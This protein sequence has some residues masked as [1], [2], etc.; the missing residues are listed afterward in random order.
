MCPALFGAAFADEKTIT[1]IMER[2]VTLDLPAERVF[3]GFYYPDYIAVGGVESFDKVVGFSREVWEGWTPAQWDL[4]RAAMPKLEELPDVG[5][6]EAGT[7]SVE[8]LLALNPDVAVLA[9]WQFMALGPDVDR[10]EEAGIKVVVV[11][12]NAETLERHLA[13]TRLFGEITGNTTRAEEIAGTYETAVTEVQR[14]IAEAGREKPRF[15]VEFANKGPAEYSFTYGKNM[16]GA[17]SDTAG[18]E[19]IAK[20]FVE[21]WGPMNPEQVLTSKPEVVLL[22]GRETE[23]KKNEEA[24]VMGVN[25]DK[26][27]AARRLEGYTKRPGWAELPAVQN[28][29]VYGVYQGA[30]RTI[31]DYAMVQFIAKAL[32]PDLFADLNPEAEYLAF[33]QKYLPITPKGTFTLKLGE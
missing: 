31:A 25:I 30:S 26:A 15:Y 33:H 3:L 21:W 8:K 27:E 18:A 20:P 13:S 29:Q 17:L 12:Y 7:F 24:L 14:R 9:E 22:A 4:Y 16:W 23:L 11:D 10:I 2:E 1:D 28:G 32:Y 6:V 5:E 19:N